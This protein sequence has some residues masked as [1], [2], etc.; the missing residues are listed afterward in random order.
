MENRNTTAKKRIAT[1]GVALATFII[2]SASF[3]LLSI[4]N[5]RQ[6]KAEV[7]DDF[8]ETSVR[9]KDSIIGQ[10]NYESLI[11]ID[12]EED[13]ESDL[14]KGLQEKLNSVRTATAARYLY[15]AHIS[16]DGVYVYGI[17]GL[18][19]EAEDFAAPGTPIEEELYGYMEKSL[20]G[21]SA[22]SGDF[23][24]TG[25]GT[26]CT[27]SFPI[28]S[29]QF[30]VYGVL[31]MEFDMEEARQGL[32][33]RMKIFWA[34][35]LL[36]SLTLSFLVTL[37][38]VRMRKSREA[39]QSAN[40]EVNRRLG[41]ILDGISGGFKISR[42]D[43]KYSFA[44]V[45]EAAAGIQGYTVDEFM[46]ATNGNAADNVY[47][48][49]LEGVLADLAKQYE[50]GD[51]YSCKYRVLHKDGSIR[52]IVDSGKRFV[53][54]GG[55][56]FNYSLYQDVTELEEQ[57]IKLN[58]TFIMLHQMLSSLS[59]GV[60]AYEIPSHKLIMVNDEAKRIFGL[61]G[62]ITSKMLKDCIE[63]FVMP[64]NRNV[65]YGA[66]NGLKG[67]G[68]GVDYTFSVC[69]DSG[70]SFIVQT[71]TKLLRLADGTNFI[72]SCMLDI[73]ERSMLDLALRQE[74]RQYRNAL[75]NNC[76]YF[77]SLDITEG[78]IYN[79]F[80][81]ANG[82]NPIRY[83]KMELPAEYDELNRRI[84]KEWHYEFDD[85][86]LED[87]FEH[88]AL[89]RQFESGV[90]K[91]E[92][93][94]HTVDKNK[95]VRA[96]VL[97]SRRMEDGHILGFVFANDITRM[98]SAEERKKRELLEAKLALE[99]AYEAAN[100]ASSAKSDF[101]SRMS[102]DIRTPMN[103]II[104]MTT[105]A[106]A[107]IDDRERVLD[108][109][110]K[111]TVSSKY[112]LGL[113]NEA[114]DMSKIES[115]KLD[116]T[117]EEFN[118]S[119]LVEELLIMMKPQIEAKRHN[120]TV[121]NHGIKHKLV[122]GDS[123]RIQQC[124]VNLM[125]NAVKYTPDGGKINFS[126]A[127]KR[128]NNPMVGCYEFV[129]E[130]N[131]IGMS[132]EFKR[133]I[134]EPFSRAEDSRVQKIQGTGLGMAITRNIVRMMDGSIDIDSELGRG[135]RVTV[136]VYLKFQEAGKAALENEG[137][138]E[139]D[140]PVTLEALADENFKGRRVLLAEDNELNAEIAGE[141]LGAAGIE[142]DYARNGK[143]ELDI[144]TAAKDGYY[145]IIFTDIQMPVMNGYEAA[146]AIRALPGE[147]PKTVPIVAMTANAFAEDV[148]AA[149]DAGMNEHI[150]KPL[151]LKQI[152]KVLRKWM[153]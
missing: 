30:G 82:I 64:N 14:Y 88:N 10:I 62:E 52:W 28:Y 105:I 124:F 119:E 91:I 114:L 142:V 19:A 98:R 93:E 127:E 6:N 57:N 80:V 73:T 85:A 117:E 128:A 33:D 17:D 130:D 23:M 90:T 141:I 67:C 3:M 5:Y 112:L 71:H 129:F 39:V 66:V 59:N 18:P 125:G 110:D 63:N 121:T 116:L 58:D 51:S 38:Y 8:R 131:G 26:V 92:A 74:R 101:L 146:R 54:D 139:S 123:Q 16:D 81:T 47:K 44:F 13:T 15:T 60:I 2:L 97:M 40:D 43:D 147:Y 107:H 108:C 25:W 103:G 77:Y 37:F 70:E 50:K 65:I 113:I 83:F 22:F 1:V 61:N 24:D 41:I 11:G 126:F 89:I 36:V 86:Q 153:R 106:R 94:Y 72:L 145:D 136:T 138:S 135:T 4:I 20:G 27:A 48:P 152:S 45:S 115:G 76:E 132:E 49:D 42:N 109:L 111:I 78:L 55:E 79:E 29:E 69:R 31:C 84:V 12:S 133:R 150:M 140:V 137:I 149:L 100:R 120:L 35:A 75:T 151:D 56:I 122:I 32:Y 68:D 87:L 9:I 53:N 102:H 34:A 134:F 7:I 148:R 144:M 143:E 46:E 104:G 95:F 96:T 99:E 21:E 118:L